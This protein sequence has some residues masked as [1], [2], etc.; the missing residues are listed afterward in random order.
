[1]FYLFKKLIIILV[2][3]LMCWLFLEKHKKNWKSNAGENETNF[4]IYLI[5]KRKIPDYEI[6][7]YSSKIKDKIE[8]LGI[9]EIESITKNNKSDSI[10]KFFEKTGS[11]FETLISGF[12]S[13]IGGYAANKLISKIENNPV[14]EHAQN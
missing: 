2:L 7:K 13:V 9:G 3:V 14:Q 10:E 6:E 4:I 5:V 8:S 11:I 1:M 12:A